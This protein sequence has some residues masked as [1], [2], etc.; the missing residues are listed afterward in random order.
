MRTEPPRI[1][2]DA[3]ETCW[4]ARLVMTDAPED[5]SVLVEQIAE[6]EELL[7]EAVDGVDAGTAGAAVRIRE[8]LENRRRLLHAIDVG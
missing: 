3:F 6:L 1:Q 7:A 5:W 8:L 2:G 4:P